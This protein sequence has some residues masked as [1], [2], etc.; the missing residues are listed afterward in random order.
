[1]KIDKKTIKS[2]LSLPD[3]KLVMMLRVIS[4]GEYPKKDPDPATLAGLRV[5]LNEVT[6]YDLNRA[7]ELISIYKKGKRH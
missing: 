1:M 3:D 7:A 2:L 5:M 4:K 6:E